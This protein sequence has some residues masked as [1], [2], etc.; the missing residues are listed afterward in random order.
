MKRSKKWSLVATALAVIVAVAIVSP[1]LGGPSLRKLVK[2]EVARQIDNA[3]AGPQ[4]QPGPPGQP[5]QPGQDGPPGQDATNLL[6]Y[7]YDEGPSFAAVVQWGS[8]VTGVTD[9]AGS[10][11]YDVTFSVSPNLQNCTVHAT[12]GTGSPSSPS[13]VVVSSEP[14]VA[15]TAFSGGGTATV[16][17]TAP[18]G[19][20]PGVS[21]TA[22]TSF[23][24]SAFC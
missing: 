24:I 5:G 6:A 15:I 23:L 19:G 3:P 11:P 13:P 8:G 12:P 18:N 17:F 16:T 7:I 4:G 22:D 20:G 2:K 1:A 21:A 10:S 14:R 9:A